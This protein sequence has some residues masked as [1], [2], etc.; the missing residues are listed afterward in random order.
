MLECNRCKEYTE[1][2]LL[3]IVP[4]AC[5]VFLGCYFLWGSD[6]SAMAKWT[7]GWL[8]SGSIILQFAVPTLWLARLLLQVALCIGM[9]IYFQIR[10]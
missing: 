8:L 5:A 7:V 6:A 9:M 1:V 3:E 2:M 10:S 4:A